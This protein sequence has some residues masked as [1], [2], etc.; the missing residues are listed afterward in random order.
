[1]K[2]RIIIINCQGVSPKVRGHDGVSYLINAWLEHGEPRL[3]IV[4]AQTGIVQQLWRLSKIG[5]MCD[6]PVRR[7]ISCIKPSAIQQLIKELFLVGCAE[8]IALVQPVRAE[9]M[10]DVCLHCNGCA[11][12]IATVN[13]MTPYTQ[14]FSE[15]RYEQTSIGQRQSHRKAQQDP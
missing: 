10:D 9:N 6:K 8:D 7:E 4:D 14:S 13:M 12:D 2:M 15:V 11:E 3:G 1:M 5:G